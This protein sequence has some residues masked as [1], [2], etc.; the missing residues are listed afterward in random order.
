MGSFL[1]QVNWFVASELGFIDE[2]ADAGVM[3]AAKAEL[4]DGVGV[5]VLSGRLV[6]IADL[7]MKFLVISCVSL[8]SIGL[9]T[10]WRNLNQDCRTVSVF[11]ELIIVWIS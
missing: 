4:A 3:A 7:I 11:I 1:V 6:L 9:P 8:K 10:I 2:L 5:D